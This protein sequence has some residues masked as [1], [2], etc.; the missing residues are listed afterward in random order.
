MVLG[1][2][3][4]LQ[5]EDRENAV[6]VAKDQF[7][8]WLLELVRDSRKA[9]KSAD[10]SGP[11]IYTL[12]VD[13]TLTVVEYSGRDESERVLLEYV[14]VVQGNSWTTR[15]YAAS[16]PKSRRLKQVLWFESEGQSADGTS[17]QPGT[18]RVVRN[19]LDTVK[20]LDGDVP[21]LG[22]PQVLGVDDVDEL[23]AYITHASRDL[24]IIVAAPVPGVPQ[25][26]WARAVASLTRDA[27]GCASFFV[28]DE[29]LLEAL[30]ARLGPSHA[31]PLGAIR[32]Y[33][34]SV[35]IGDWID[36]RRHRT[37]TAKS[38]AIGLG[39]KFRFSERLIRAIATGPR[40]QILDAALP[41]DLTR[42][43]R[44][45]QRERLNLTSVEASVD[46]GGAVTGSVR[47]IRREE[48]A[49]ISTSIDEAIK[50]SWM[51]NLGQLVNRVT[52][53]SDINAS[54][55]SSVIDRLELQ[56]AVARVA[57]DNAARLQAQRER[58]EDQIAEVR[59]QLEA[60]QF[61]RA[62]ADMGRRDAEKNAR[63]LERWRADREDS[64]T[65]TKTQPHDWETDPASV[66]EIIERLTDK[67]GYARF[68]PYVELTDFNK[69]IDRAI[70][71]DAADPNGTYASAFWEYI[72]ILNDYMAQCVENEL[73]MNVHM[74]LVSDQTTGRKCP[75]QRHRPNESVTVQNNSK[76]RR[77]RTFVVPTEVDDA[78][79]MFMTTHFAPTHRDQNAPRMY[80]Y[81]DI[82]G[83]KKAYIGY[84]GVHLT[85]TKTN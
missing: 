8:S 78:G 41:G 29:A 62:L 11:G 70:T 31:V 64:Y 84:I 47:E 50:P 15:L 77:E 17:L 72:L 27:L 25:S 54:S 10:W 85:N 67:D 68:L 65:F 36:A 26:D 43:V 18:P 39:P 55:V 83:T 48:A 74:Y 71:V 52:G 30:N 81:A 13:S 69:A 14:E 79:E 2:R 38:L 12:G 73:N 82:S 23:F 59:R 56:E 61:E 51:D 60:E 75:V 32:T 76:M 21:V 24:S 6:R 4:V 44:V 37:L 53:K 1:Y 66:V 80:Y 16:A 40:L 42:T 7:R 46:P 20:A 22:S 3:A 45:L 28:L 49:Q 9:I 19:T 33:M 58:L 57:S 35:G 63:A 34:P 5:L